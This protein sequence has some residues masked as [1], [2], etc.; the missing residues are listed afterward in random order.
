MYEQRRQKRVESQALLKTLK[1]DEFSRSPLR[2]SN[3]GVQASERLYSM[4]KY[5]RGRINSMRKQHEDQEFS[6]SVNPSICKRSES[7]IKNRDRSGDIGNRLY[8]T[9][10]KQ[11]Q[12]KG[13]AA[14]LAV[15]ISKVQAVPSISP[16]AAK[17][18]RAGSVSDR[19]HRYKKH[20]KENLEN[21]R[22]EVQ[23]VPSFTPTIT[24]R[25]SRSPQ[26][27]A[28]KKPDYEQF[29]FSPNVSFKAT[30]NHSIE[31]QLRPQR[32]AGVG[33]AGEQCAGPVLGGRCEAVYKETTQQAVKYG[34]SADRLL[35]TR[36]L[37]SLDDLLSKSQLKSRPRVE[38]TGKHE[39]TEGLWTPRW[40]N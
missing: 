36:P 7:L 20:Y 26:P 27:R 30:P 9:G 24:R 38:E 35:F 32:D 12:S 5:Y 29:T 11:Q 13:K 16:F 14:E 31:A 39:A 28:S 17:M 18:K 8:Q 1:E 2:P 25:N 34:T 6:A 15:Y 33:S 40:E 23:E 37:P 22:Q 19:L 4:T 3:D 21:L 10:L